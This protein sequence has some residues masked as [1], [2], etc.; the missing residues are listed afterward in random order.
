MLSEATHEHEAEGEADRFNKIFQRLVRDPD[1]LVGLVAYGIY[2]QEKRDWIIRHRNEYSRRPS[3]DEVRSFNSHYSDMALE[4]FRN[5]AES[6]MIDFAEVV[7]ESRAPEIERQAVASG[8]NSL[9]VAISEASD[10]IKN[11]VTKQTSP[12]WSVIW[13]IVAW[14]LTLVVTVAV[15]GTL[16]LPNI[17]DKLTVRLTAGETPPLVSGPK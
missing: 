8:I 15:A 5:E 3:D 17:V 6:M 11:H 2:K 13:N 7:V 10:T 1:D 12:L 4:R 16:L 14:V 9:K